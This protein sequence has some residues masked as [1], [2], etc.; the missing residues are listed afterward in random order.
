MAK[1]LDNSQKV[2]LAEPLTIIGC[3]S[4]SEAVQ[5]KSDTLNISHHIRSQVDLL[6]YF[7]IYKSVLC[8]L[9]GL[10]LLNNYML[11]FLTN[12]SIDLWLVRWT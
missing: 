1:C 9:N 10:K 3:A 6:L 7:S 12:F 2:L 11:A 5:I 4:H 8:H